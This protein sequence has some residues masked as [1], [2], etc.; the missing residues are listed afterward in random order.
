MP[1]TGGHR[2]TSGLVQHRA[3]RGTPAFGN[4]RWALVVT[5]LC[6]IQ[7]RH[8]LCLAGICE[9]G[10]VPQLAQQGSD[11]LRTESGNV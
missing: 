6:E 5:R 3:R 4:M 9:A 10:Q 11:D 7:P 1:S 2:D 8:L